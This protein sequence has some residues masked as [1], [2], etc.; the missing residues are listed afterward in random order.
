MPYSYSSSW[1]QHKLMSDTGQ[2]TCLQRAHQCWLVGNGSHG[3]TGFFLESFRV[4]TTRHSNRLKVATDLQSS[5][6]LCKLP[7]Y[8]LA[9][10][11]SFVFPWRNHNL[12][13]QLCTSHTCLSK[14]DAMALL[15]LDG[16]ACWCSTLPSLR[17]LPTS[18]L[19]R[20]LEETS[21]P[22]FQEMPKATETIQPPDSA[23]PS[24]CAW[25]EMATMRPPS[26]LPSA[27]L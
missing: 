27:Q 24:A 20:L 19:H 1:G 13:L 16:Y 21:I 14:E 4:Q 15:L 25:Q 11:T 8:A 7:Q 17:C 23:L 2:S 10:L 26:A 5:W 3:A 22:N 12:I 18:S 6:H 9:C